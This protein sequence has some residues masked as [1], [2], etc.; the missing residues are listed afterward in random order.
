MVC[1]DHLS[2]LSRLGGR[3]GLQHKRQVPPGG[4]LVQAAPIAARRS[5]RTPSSA[6]P[7]E[8]APAAAG[9]AG[10]PG[11]PGDRGFRSGTRPERGSGSGVG[12][13]GPQGG[14]VR[15]LVAELA[16]GVVQG[17]RGVA[18]VGWRACRRG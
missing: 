17:V 7:G 10:Q 12:V 8:A 6:L 14:L 11:L 1:A 18:G 5:S 9:T 16:G 2:E 3:A 13:G 15:V 4:D